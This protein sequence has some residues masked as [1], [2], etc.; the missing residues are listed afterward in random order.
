M[1]AAGGARRGPGSGPPSPLRAPRRRWGRAA[2][3]CPWGAP[4]TTRLESWRR[5]RGSAA[6]GRRCPVGA[7]LRLGPAAPGW[8]LRKRRFARA[9]G[10]HVT[11]GARQE[12]LPAP[13][14]APRVPVLHGWPWPPGRPPRRRSMAWVSGAFVAE[15]G[16]AGCGLSSAGAARWRCSVVSWGPGP[17]GAAAAFGRSGAAGSNVEWKGAAGLV[18]GWAGSH[19][20]GGRAPG[21]CWGC[22]FPRLGAGS[23]LPSV[24]GFGLSLDVEARSAPGLFGS[25]VTR[26]V[27]C[28]HF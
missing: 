11:R 19:G 24:L 7:G 13:H 8:V 3:S 18:M 26:A 6:L 4:A 27:D 5:R 14:A 17:H 25:S 16:A 21:Q 9:G 1:A 10:V 2:P 28:A 20:A 22:A 12:E 15:Q 23:V